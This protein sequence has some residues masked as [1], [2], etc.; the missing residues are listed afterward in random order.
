EITQEHH[1]VSN[2]ARLLQLS[3]SALE[4]LNEGEN[5]L[6][7][8]AGAVGRTVH[9]LQRVDSGASSLTE[10][11]E[12]AVATWRELQ[13][14]LSRYVDKMDV[15]PARLAELDE[16]LNLIHSLKRKYGSTLAAVIEFGAEA[17]AKLQSL[18][19]RD[20]ELARINGALE[21]LD[22][23]LLSAGK[24]LSAARQKVIP[25]LS[26]AVARQL[27]DLGF[28]QGKFDIAL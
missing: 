4:L 16:R 6:L 8:Q 22:S 17:K 18:E 1:R 2:A 10:L 5:S 23:Q 13:T 27:A 20:A 28:K 15:E 24:K 11:H 12:Q 3:Q 21:K 7:T 26:K 19:S 25:K 14:E 9:E